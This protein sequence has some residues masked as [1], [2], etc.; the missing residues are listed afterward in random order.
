MDEIK[1]FEIKNQKN[2]I[3]YETKLSNSKDK[4]IIKVKKIRQN[5]IEY[6]EKDF[7]LEDIQKVKLFTIYDNIDEC[8]DD[9]ISG[10]NTNKS[11]IKEDNN[12]IYLTIPL[13]NKKYTSISF[14]IFIKSKDQIIEE[15]NNL[16]RRLTEENIRLKKEITNIKQKNNII[17]I[18][19]DEN[20]LINLK[21]RQ[22]F[23]RQYNL[24]STN[25]IRYLIELVKKNV[26]ICEYF[27][28]RYNNSLIDNY[29]LTFGDYN[30]ADNSTIDFIDYK[31]GGQ[32]FVKTL[33]GKT[34]VLDLEASDTIEIVKKKIQDKEGI[35][36]D[37]QRLVFAGKQLEDTRTIKDYEIWNESTI[38]LILKLR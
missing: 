29:N 3:R 18:N 24:K 2:N 38:H 7:S 32:C 33:T 22:G 9:I 19:E 8:M 25:T 30:I 4:L 10:I 23:S 5:E 36:P 16:I 11:D 13:L 20:L 28:I 1:I 14:D 26:C 21:F 34:I 27:Q 12:H 6:F 35:P 17:P 15:Q 37:Q 31:I